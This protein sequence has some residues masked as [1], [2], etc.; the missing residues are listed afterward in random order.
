M[1]L[2]TLEMEAEDKILEVAN[3]LDKLSDS[4]ER[5]GVGMRAHS[6]S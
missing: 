1:I 3:G 4:K 2:L 5:R 6:C